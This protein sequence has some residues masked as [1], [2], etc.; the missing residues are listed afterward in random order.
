MARDQ[1]QVQASMA[2]YW[3]IATFSILDVFWI[4]A[5]IIVNQ[6]CKPYLCCCCGMFVT[7]LGIWPKGRL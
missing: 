1:L 2:R 3:K 4:S 7:A 6:T 5:S